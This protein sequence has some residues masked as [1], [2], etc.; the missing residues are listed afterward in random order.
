MGGNFRN[1]SSKAK[2]FLT[3]S[4]KIIF[5]TLV[6]QDLILLGAMAI[7]VPPAAGPVWTVFSPILT[8]FLVLTLM[9]IFI[10]L[11][12]ILIIPCFSLLPKRV[13]HLLIKFFILTASSPNKIFHFDNFLL[14]YEGCHNCVTK[15]WTNAN[16]TNPLLSFSQ[17]VTHTRANIIKWKYAGLRPINL[18]L[19]NIN[20][21]IARMEAI[22]PS[23]SDTWTDLW[24][25]SLYNRHNAFLC[26]NFLY[27]SQRA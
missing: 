18:E 26:Q 5:W 19:S 22:D 1:Y 16:N 20:Q 15:A 12:L 7:L 13:L 6:S 9:L 10:F 11:V 3:S 8:G 17:C 25:R 24:L 2:N 14:Y 27:W 4:R 23:S 21:E